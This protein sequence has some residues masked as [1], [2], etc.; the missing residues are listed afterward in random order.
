[1]STEEKLKLKIGIIGAGVAGMSAAL[2]LKNL[3]HQVSIFERDNK[4]E[5]LGAGIQISSNGRYVLEK[6]G[7]DNETI[8]SSFHDNPIFKSEY[9]FMIE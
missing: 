6:L 1:M 3:G 7:L 5:R 8:I 2:L 4:L 9:A